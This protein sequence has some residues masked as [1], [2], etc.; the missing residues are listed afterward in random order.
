M[1][2]DHESEN[3]NG[4]GLNGA[5]MNGAGMNGH[6][7]DNVSSFPAAEE[8]SA[9]AAAAA[10]AE[11]DLAAAAAQ[12]NKSEPIL[13][14]PA[15]VKYLSLLLL[16]GMGLRYILP[17]ET[18]YNI[19]MH[20]GFVPARY[21]GVMDFDWRAAA[22][23]VTHMFLHGGWLHIGVNIG[24]L[25]AFGSALE[26]TIGIK[27]TALIFFLSGAL[28]AG[29]HFAVMPQDPAPL[30]G[31]SG[32]IS[33]LFGGM[34]ILMFRSGL[35]GGE[36][37]RRLIFLIV[38]WIGISLAFGFAGMPGTEGKVAWTAHV[39]GFIAGLALYPFLVRE[40]NLRLE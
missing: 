5:G 33:G 10:A 31:A 28:G 4:G 16:A 13:N 26:R 39:G 35:L 7:Q 22:A 9:R 18:L 36:G 29:L 37:Y 23:P 20:F 14:L 40:K 34:L 12:K 30:I 1:S 24:M 38:L 15:G 2:N 3:Q 32:G 6:A 17:D 11:K 8:R 25:M 27:R 19:Y 21:S